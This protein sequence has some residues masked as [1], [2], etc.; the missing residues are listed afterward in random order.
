MVILNRPESIRRTHHSVHHLV[1]RTR[2]YLIVVVS[3]DQVAAGG[4]SDALAGR[5]ALFERANSTSRCPA[6]FAEKIVFRVAGGSLWVLNPRGCRSFFHDSTDR[7]VLRLRILGRVGCSEIGSGVTFVR[8]THRAQVAIVS[9]VSGTEIAASNHA[10]L[11][12]V[13]WPSSLVCTNCVEK[14]F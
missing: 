6:L 9:S 3:D 12:N 7:S 10:L 1:R 2:R 8:N 14:K 13:M 11:V 5:D 4:G